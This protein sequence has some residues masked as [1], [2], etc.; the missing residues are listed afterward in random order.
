MIVYS[1]LYDESILH[2]IGQ[3][4]MATEGARMRDE[5]LAFRRLQ[6]EQEDPG[7][8]LNF[9]F[10]PRQYHGIPDYQPGVKYH[11]EQWDPTGEAPY[12]L[13]W[14]PFWPEDID[15]VF[16]LHGPG[17]AH[18]PAL[19]NWSH[20]TLAQTIAPPGQVLLIANQAIHLEDNDILDLV[21]GEVP[22]LDPLLNHRLLELA[23]RAEA[24]DLLD[25]LGM[26][27][28]PSDLGDI[29][30]TTHEIL[31]ELTGNGLNVVALGPTLSGGFLNGEESTE[32][33]LL[34]DLLPEPFLPDPEAEPDEVSYIIKTQDE[35]GDVG[36]T[37]QA[38]ANMA[39]NA[40]VL[41][42]VG[43]LGGVIAVAGDVYRIDA[44]IQSNAHSDTDHVDGQNIGTGD[45]GTATYNYASFSHVPMLYAAPVPEGEEPAGG[46]ENW[47]ICVVD[48]DLIFAQWVVQTNF[49]HDND[50]HV[51]TETGAYSNFVTGA[52]LAHNILDFSDL[53]KVYDLILIGGNLYD[54]NIIKQ[55]N[56]LLDDD[57]ITVGGG[58]GST[59][60]SSGNLLYNGA[61]ITNMGAQNWLEGLP[62]HYLEALERLS[63]GNAK[64]PDGFADDPAFAGF[65]GISV[66]VV[67]GNVYDLH[68]IGQTNVVGDADLVASAEAAAL[69]E[70]VDNGSD[71]D[72]ST[73]E[74]ALVNTASILDTDSLGDVAYVGGEL[75]SDAVLIQ[76]DILAGPS[77]DDP[78]ALVYEAIAFLTTDDCGNVFEADDGITLVPADSQS[79][80]VLSSVLT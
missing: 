34:D 72:I 12:Q 25:V 21:G 54:A 44:I 31:S 56:V 1:A 45:N 11:P 26:P 36:L 30:T 62:Q 28:G 3:W 17:D 65:D 43:L 58:P 9:R 8:L 70:A 35:V 71:W 7:D 42:N 79:V 77:D 78:D 80:D 22:E 33:P 49:V 50:I 23:A 32:A 46:P 59:A 68:Y 5:L 75:Y 53:G 52:N 38:G 74:N 76:S 67:T 10:N 37:L 41:S 47:A 6:Q 55:V 4:H 14:L 16:H 63:S 19:H 64:I 40:A 61:S 15:K 69:Q 18:W 24:I 48:G 13:S 57:C 39:M 66:L 73:G 2:F 20:P 29:V 51:L 27:H 60:N